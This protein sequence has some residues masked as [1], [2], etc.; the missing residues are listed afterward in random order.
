MASIKNEDQPKSEQMGPHPITA[1]TKVILKEVV[2]IYSWISLKRLVT[3][4][5]SMCN[6]LIHR[7][8][9]MCQKLHIR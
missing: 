2:K 6:Q 1:M 7:C 8:K 4:K 5:V 9:S 3:L